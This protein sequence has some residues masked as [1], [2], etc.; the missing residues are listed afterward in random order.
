MKSTIYPLVLVLLGMAKAGFAS[1]LSIDVSASPSPVGASPYGPGTVTNPQGQELTLD[2][3][4][5]FLGGQPWIPVVG[6]F[7]YA[8][9]PRNEWRDELL[10][11]KAGGINTVSTYVFW[12]HHEEEQGK[13]DWSG[14]R[15]L[16]DF[17]TLC[18]EVGLKAFVRMGPWCHGEA[19]NG[20]FPDWV[21]N[22][23]ANLRSNDPA[24][25]KLVEPFFKEQAKQ[26]EGLLWKD[27]GP[28]VGIQLDNEN[29]NG[30]YLLTLKDMARADGV[31]VPFYA[32]TGWQGGVP[33]AGLLPLF[34]GYVDGFWGGSHEEY[35][36]E[37]IFSDV[38]AVN[39]LGAQLIT[40]NPDNSK[41]LAQFPYACVEIGPGMMSG[42][43]K[44]I[45]IV[46][47]DAAAMALAK[48]GSGNNMPGYYMFHGGTNPEGK[49]STL[50]EDHPNQL[51][52]K[53][54]DFQTALGADGQVREQFHLLRQQHLF[55]QDFGSS[56]ARM[57]AYFPGQ[58]PANLNDFD[59]LRWDMRSDGKTGFLFF[60]NRQPYEPLPEHKDVQFEVKT[61]TGS[62]LIPRHPTTIPSG[63]Y[64][65]W[66]VNLDCGGVTLE[67]A[68]TQPLCRI[69]ASN[70]VV[71]FF[72]A[73]DGIAPE[74][75]LRA[76]TNKVQVTAG[77]SENLGEAVRVYNLKP[78]TTPVASVTKANKSSVSF[79][80]LTPEQGRELYRASFA[81]SDRAILSGATVLDDGNALRLQANSPGD[82]MFS[83][84]PPVMGLKSGTA[85]LK[86]QGDGIFT[87]FAPTNLR[88]PTPLNVPSALVQPAGPKA[89]SLRGTDEATWQDAAVYKL[90]IP[91][92]A[93]NRHVLLNIH[94]IGDAARLYVGDKLFDDNFYNGDPFP[95]ALWRIPAT[96][97]PNIHLKVLPFSDGLMGR[98]PDF[99]T[100]KIKTARANGTLDQ[101]TTTTSEQLE[102]RLTSTSPR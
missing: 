44:R 33:S 50:H 87:R 84:F 82:L 17:L 15:S 78:G 7:H 28:V 14:Q 53:N 31:D 6:E 83:V 101:I 55:L 42:Y 8:R 89:T 81:G 85:K 46:P 67:Y 3:R 97:W 9:Y 62:L 91:A 26:M 43:G 72:A 66:P 10:K 93:A 49:L 19:R 63:S 75:L 95:L 61:A 79:V 99:A 58:R 37:V 73:L 35:R 5:F 51:P 52:V 13:F 71:Y 39:D 65:I 1:P 16:R 98:L 34:G 11:M 86:G 21:Q 64:G 80:V 70:G 36:R 29:G 38:R 22:S 96:D 88:A 100:E 12:I 60:N 25:L 24:F 56:L 92:S 102:W 23:G 68:T 54:Y 69:A 30:D 27:G 77:N 59:T 45:K 41:K 76:G 32:M 94:Y 20:G 57:P 2:S 90:S 4:S 18:Q 47:D 48:L 40:R 74:L